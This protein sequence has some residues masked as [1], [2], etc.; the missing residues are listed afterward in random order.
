MGVAT[1]VLCPYANSWP[2]TSARVTGLQPFTLVS[3][4]SHHARH[5]SH[6]GTNGVDCTAPRGPTNCQ[7]GPVRPQ[8]AVY[9]RFLHIPPTRPAPSC[10]LRG[11]VFRGLRPDQSSHLSSGEPPAT[12][13]IFPVRH[14]YPALVSINPSV[15]LR[16][17]CVVHL[18]PD[19][20]PNRSSGQL[21]LGRA[22]KGVAPVPSSETKCYAPAERCGVAQYLGR[23]RRGSP[24]K[25]LH[26]RTTERTKCPWLHCRGV[27]PLQHI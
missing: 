15:D 13:W 4:H 12:S 18:S 7:Y 20:F 10:C 23:E 5:W 26:N 25:R 19:R 16:V 3:A 22:A 6:H 27:G 8:P 9:V 2:H 14:S 21:R 11:L 1:L 24:K 17:H